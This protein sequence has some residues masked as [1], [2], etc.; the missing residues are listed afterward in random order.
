MSAK[1]K[2]REN[3][4]SSERGSATIEAVLWMP[5][6]F[7]LFILMA[8]SA[9]IFNGQ[10]Q[11]MR[12][13]HDGNRNYSIGRITSEAETETYI[14]TALANYGPNLKAITRVDNGVI[15]TTVSVPATD[16]TATKL[17]AAVAPITL[18]IASQHLM[19]R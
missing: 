12:I 9:L 18:Q 2:F 13:I 8:D 14:E 6:F 19:E 16:L 11:I 3:F 5:M 7:G 4:I 15:T 10:S 17:L 1:Q